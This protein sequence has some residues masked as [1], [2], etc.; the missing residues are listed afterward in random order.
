[1]SMMM[2]CYQHLTAGG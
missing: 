2:L 1:M